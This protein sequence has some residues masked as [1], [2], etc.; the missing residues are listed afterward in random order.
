M[1][2]IVQGTCLFNVHSIRFHN[3]IQKKKTCLSCHKVAFPIP[4]LWSSLFVF[5]STVF[6]TISFLIILIIL[7]GVRAQ[8]RTQLPRGRR[9]NIRCG[10]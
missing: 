6:R 2:L 10:L 4:S 3:G 1:S 7:K 5:I 8:W 9:D